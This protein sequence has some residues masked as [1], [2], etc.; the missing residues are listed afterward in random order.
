MAY[1]KL[2]T[3][4]GNLTIGSVYRLFVV[5]WVLGFGILFTAIALFIFVSAAITGEANI[6]G[7]HVRDRTQVIATF[8]PVLAVPIIIFVQ[9]FI[10]AGLMTFGVRIY[11]LWSPLTVESTSGY[12]KL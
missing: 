9:G 7:V 5:G 4:N 12:E 11:R 6:N 8:A 2:E 3:I 10:A 1:L